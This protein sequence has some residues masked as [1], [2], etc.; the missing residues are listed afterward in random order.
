[1]FLCGY[2]KQKPVFNS[3][4]RQNVPFYQA[5]SYTLVRNID[6]IYFSQ[7]KSELGKSC[8]KG[9]EGNDSQASHPSLGK[10]TVFAGLDPRLLFVFPTQKFF[11]LHLVF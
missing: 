7:L 6:N 3:P 8:R 4:P 10:T 9:V 1:M 5:V 11:S 2:C